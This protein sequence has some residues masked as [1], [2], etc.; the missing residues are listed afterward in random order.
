[1]LLRHSMTVVSAAVLSRLPARTFKYEGA[2]SGRYVLMSYRARSG[3]EVV[4]TLA[5]R[6]C[7]PNAILAG[8]GDCRE[9]T[10]RKLAGVRRY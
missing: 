1:M 5:R 10:P 7:H 9:K 3:S 2:A 8:V 6:R 4:T